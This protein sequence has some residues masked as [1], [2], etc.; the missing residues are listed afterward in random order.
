MLRC[1][2]KKEL[3]EGNDR[4]KAATCMRWLSI[5]IDISVETVTAN[6]FPKSIDK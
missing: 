3:K 2:P 4:I 5:K 6:L 1:Y